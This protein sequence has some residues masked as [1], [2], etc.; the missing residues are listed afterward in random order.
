M[1]RMP[2]PGLEQDEELNRIEADF[3]H[4]FSTLVGIDFIHNSGSVQTITE[5]CLRRRAARH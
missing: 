2:R 5:Q 1:A 4:G 3:M